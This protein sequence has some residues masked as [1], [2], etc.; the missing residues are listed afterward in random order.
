MN[1][2]GTLKAHFDLIVTI[3][4]FYIDF[5]ES[6]NSVSVFLIFNY[7]SI[8][9]FDSI[10]FCPSYFLGLLFVNILSTSIPLPFFTINAQLISG[11][12]IPF[13]NKQ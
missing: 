5:V 8:T 7:I 9:F 12:N 4:A 13:I 10:F 1:E 3:F 11:S 6:K 2:I